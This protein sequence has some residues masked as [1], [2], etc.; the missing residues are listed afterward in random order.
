MDCKGSSKPSDH[1]PSLRR[2][3]PVADGSPTRH[4][5]ALTGGLMPE[6]GGQ[7]VETTRDPI[8]VDGK[9]TIK[10]TLKPLEGIIAREAE[11]D[12][13]QPANNE[14]TR[15]QHAVTKHR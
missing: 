5:L 3:L 2:L 10:A 8:E 4:S 7:V 13:R 6:I 1:S 11:A 14:L 15:G 9:D 12:A